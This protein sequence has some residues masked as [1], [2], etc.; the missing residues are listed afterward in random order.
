[1]CTYNWCLSGQFWNRIKRKIFEGN[2]KNVCSKFHEN[3]H[4]PR[5]PSF[6]PPPHRSTHATPVPIVLYLS[7]QV[8]ALSEF[9][10]NTEKP[11]ILGNMHSLRPLPESCP[12]RFL[13]R[14]T[15]PP[16]RASASNAPLSEYI[17]WICVSYRK[18]EINYKKNIRHDDWGAR[19]TQNRKNLPKYERKKF[20][21]REF[22]DIT[23]KFF[24]ARV[25]TGILTTDSISTFWT[26][27]FVKVLKKFWKFTPQNFWTKEKF[28]Q[29]FRFLR[30]TQRI[31][32][33]NFAA[34]YYKHPIGRP[35]AYESRFEQQ[36]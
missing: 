36:K 32:S 10:R 24:G 20:L 27:R 35:V 26:R 2:I 33:K 30:V 15:V 14:W 6:P 18:F 3:V 17:L 9:W 12:T 21:D 31:H 22:D 7:V 19:R 25:P 8:V 4:Y 16:F 1:M 23:F 28:L 29:N 13:P 11:F 5:F 34:L